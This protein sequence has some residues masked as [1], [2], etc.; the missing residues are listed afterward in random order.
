LGLVK[1]NDLHWTQIIRWLG[2]DVVALTVTIICYVSISNFLSEPPP[3]NLSNTDT[4]SAEPSSWNKILHSIGAYVSLGFLCLT[5]SLQ[6]SVPSGIYYL[7]FLGGA[8]WWALSKN[9]INKAFARIFSILAV[10]VAI[11]I[12]ALFLYQLEW[13]QELIDPKSLVARFVNLTF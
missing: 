10:F 2:P 3:L 12:I 9:I 6:P 5:S 1:L 4:N 7:I 8:T 13:S 11:H